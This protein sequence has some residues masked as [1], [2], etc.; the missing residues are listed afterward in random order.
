MMFSIHVSCDRLVFE[1]ILADS[2]FQSN[3]IKRE[4]KL[5]DFAIRVI[6]CT[7]VGSYGT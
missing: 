1:G 4:K 3:P 6:F 2:H 7:A 5:I